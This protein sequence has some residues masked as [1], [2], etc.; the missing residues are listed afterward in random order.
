EDLT[1]PFTSE[2]LLRFFDSII[3][4]SKLAPNLNLVK[5]AFYILLAY[6]EFTWTESDRFKI[7][8]HD[9]RRL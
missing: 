5:K 9:G 7:S 3:G 4:T 8:R 2:D 6:S 1:T